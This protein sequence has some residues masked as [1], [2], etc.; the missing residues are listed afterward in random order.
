MTHFHP[1]LTLLLFAASVLLVA[2]PDFRELRRGHIWNVAKSEAAEADLHGVRVFIDEARAMILPVMDDR[3]LIYLRLGLQGNPEVLK[4]WMMCDLG[5]T[6]SR[7]RKWLP[8]LNL[9]G[10]EIV[11][12]LGEDSPVDDSC[13][14]SLIFAVSEEEPALSV[15]AFLVPIDVLNELRLE[16]AAMTTRPDAVSLPFRP[17]LRPPPG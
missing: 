10:V 11:N 4:G 3:A 5:L 8:L 17:V 12:M 2:W 9:A 1:L 13:N 6:D 7:G 15:Q 14:Q 16:F